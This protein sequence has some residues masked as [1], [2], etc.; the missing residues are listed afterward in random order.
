MDEAKAGPTDAAAP[1]PIPAV[2]VLA[3]APQ[4]KTPTKPPATEAATGSPSGPPAAI[5]PA[6]APQSPRSSKSIRLGGLSPGER[7]T[8]LLQSEFKTAGVRASSIVNE[9]SMTM[10]VVHMQETLDKMDQAANVDALDKLVQAFIAS[11]AAVKQMA[12]ATRKITASLKE[13]LNALH[14]E[15][16]G[17]A[18]KKRLANEASE[19]E[20]QRK[21][22]KDLADEIRKAQAEAQPIFGVEIAKHIEKKEIFTEAM[23]AII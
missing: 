19:M 10:N 23:G 18:D 4:D 17:Q 12:A 16:S 5:T 7:L 13:Q 15:T 1:E 22:A 11:Q 20:G 21:R 8:A 9:T 6:A 3:D 2:G 14:K